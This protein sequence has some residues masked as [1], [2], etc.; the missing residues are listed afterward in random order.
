MRS[1]VKLHGSP[2]M[3]TLQLAPSAAPLTRRIPDESRISRR[4]FRFAVLEPTVIPNVPSPLI[5]LSVTVRVLTPLPLTDMLA[6][7]S[8][9][10]VFKV[11]SSALSV[12]LYLVPSIFS[13]SLVGS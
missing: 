2:K 3:L 11:M 12:M 8:P 13:L 1:T 10:V 5:L 4:G 6:L 7:S 9:V